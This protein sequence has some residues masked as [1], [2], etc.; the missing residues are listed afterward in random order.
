[1][2]RPVNPKTRFLPLFLAGAILLAL[3]IA[4]LIGRPARSPE[5]IEMLQQI[6]F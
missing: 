3:L 5:S 6:V 1:V 4:W 2:F